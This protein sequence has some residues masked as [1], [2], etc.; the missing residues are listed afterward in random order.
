MEAKDTVMT[1]DKLEA[2]QA[3]YSEP[4]NE[5]I[6]YERN[7]AKAQAELTW[8][9]CQEDTCRRIAG[10]LWDGYLFDMNPDSSTKYIIKLAKSLKSGK[11]PEEI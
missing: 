1:S 10:L 4:A 9:A 6:G 7:I 11:L 8:K 2:I 5:S 3:Y